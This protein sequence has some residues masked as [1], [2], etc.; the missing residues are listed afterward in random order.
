MS[1]RWSVGETTTS[2][3]GFSYARPPG[4]PTNTVASSDDVPEAEA[5]ACTPQGRTGTSTTSSS[6]ASP[7]AAVTVSR[8]LSPSG[9]SKASKRTSSTPSFLTSIVFGKTCS[10]PP[11]Y[12]LSFRSTA[13]VTPTW[14]TWATNRGRSPWV[15]VA[16]T[17]RSTKKSLRTTSSAV[18]SPTSVSDPVTPRAVN[19]YSERAIG[20]R[21]ETRALPSLPVTTDGFQYAVSTNRSRGRPCSASR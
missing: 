17:F 8:T 1:S 21:N 6:F 10:R 5:N 13:P 20:A 12:A 19:R 11:A 3:S 18:D 7:E 16:G 2:I 14:L 9:T 15:N 4:R